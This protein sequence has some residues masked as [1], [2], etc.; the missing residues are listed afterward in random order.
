MGQRSL[1][2]LEAARVSKLI[3]A[4]LVVALW[5]AAAR[6][7]REAGARI[8]TRALIL[9]GCR[10]RRI[11]EESG[12]RTTRSSPLIPASCGRMESGASW[13]SPRPRTCAPTLSLFRAAGLDPVF[14]LA[15][16]IG[17]GRPAALV[18]P[19]D[20]ALILSNAAFY[21]YAALVYSGTA[22]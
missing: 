1:R 4:R 12:S 5:D 8:V 21:E 7:R 2:V 17:A 13:S 9:R 6:S 3:G 15:V 18:I 16:A 14:S 20:D 11:V 19:T 10:Q 22:G